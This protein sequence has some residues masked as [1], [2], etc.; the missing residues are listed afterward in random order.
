MPHRLCTTC[1]KAENPLNR[2][3]FTKHLDGKVYCENCLPVNVEV[4]SPT[5]PVGKRSSPLPGTSAGSFV[6]IPCPDCVGQGRAPQGNGVRCPA[7]SG[8]A[9]V[10]IPENFLNVYRPKWNT[11]EKETLTEG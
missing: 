6:V 5:P 4:L 7:C 3:R 1:K 9:R 2:L 10:R 11:P 8:W